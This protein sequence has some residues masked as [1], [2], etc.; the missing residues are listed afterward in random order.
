MATKNNPGK[1]DCYEPEGRT[2]SNRTW[3]KEEVYD[4]EISRAG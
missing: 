3:D 4:R 2:M 1:F